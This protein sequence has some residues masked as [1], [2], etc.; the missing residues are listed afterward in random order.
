MKDFITC[1]EY[2]EE[3]EAGFKNNITYNVSGFD[4]IG[5]SQNHWDKELFREVK[6]NSGLDLYLYDSTINN[7]LNLQCHHDDAPFL[8]SKFYRSGY[9]NIISPGVEN[10]EAEYNE[11]GGI[12]Y[13]FYLPEIQEIEQFFAGDR[14]D[15]L[16]ID[17]DVNYLRIFFERL[18]YIPQQLKAVIEK[19]N[20]PKFHR[21]V[22]KVTPMMRTVIEQIWQHPYQ[23]ALARMY[24]EGKILELLVLQLSQLIDREKA[25]PAAIKLLPTDIDRIHQA[26]D[27][28]RHNYL[29]PPSIMDLAQQVGLDRMKLKRGFRYIFNT[30]PFSDLQNYRLDLARMLLQDEQMTVTAVANR[31]GY[32]N[33]SYFSRAFKRRFGITPGQCRAR[34][35]IFLD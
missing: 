28:L 22:G 19:D 11:K 5:K 27:I 33:I 6:L 26:R 2:D 31:I 32:S 23:D 1:K 10:V 21:P 29:N 20:A 17:I 13:L 35:A 9:H 24:L 14:L 15:R 3:W 18:D 12:N 34:G 8:T 4:R 16:I 30:T 25:R 7:N